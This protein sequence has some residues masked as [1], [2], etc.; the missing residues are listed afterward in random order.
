[1]A[2]RTREVTVQTP[3]GPMTSMVEVEDGS[4]GGINVDISEQVTSLLGEHDKTQNLVMELGGDVREGL[5]EM[6]D[7][8]I[9]ILLN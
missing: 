5:L 8:L 4:D 1:M 7:I 9:K 6:K 2:T 3:F